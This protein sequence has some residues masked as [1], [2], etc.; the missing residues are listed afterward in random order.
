[1]WIWVVKCT[2][3]HGYTCDRLQEADTAP[4]STGVSLAL[5]GARLGGGGGGGAAGLTCCHRAVPRPS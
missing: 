5:A 4:H 3:W 1:M 2:Q